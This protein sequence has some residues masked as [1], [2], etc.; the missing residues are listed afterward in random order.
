ME[1]NAVAA[2]FLYTHGTVDKLLLELLYFAVP[3][4]SD[5]PAREVCRAAL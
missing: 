2:C 5:T 4:S 3:E 1:L